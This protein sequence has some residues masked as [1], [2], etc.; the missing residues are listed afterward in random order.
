MIYLDGSVT[1]LGLNLGDD[2]GNR[3]VLV[4]APHL[5]ELLTLN[6]AESLLDKVLGVLCGDTLELVSIHGNPD[7]VADL[8][9]GVD[10]ARVLEDDLDL[11]LV[12]GVNHLD[13]FLK[14]AYIKYM[15]V[16]VYVYE[17][18]FAILVLEVHVRLEALLDSALYL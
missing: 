16:E 9:I 18:D 13:D 17:Y 2:S 5:A 8:R 11:R 6:I 4:F 10:L 14:Y 1:G 7:V 3:L 12:Q 15:P